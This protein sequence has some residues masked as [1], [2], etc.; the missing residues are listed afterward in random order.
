[1]PGLEPKALLHAM[2]DQNASDLHIKVGVPPMIRVHGDMAPLPGF[3][4]LSS[5]DTR[6]IALT[7]FHVDPLSK[8]RKMP[9]N[10]V[11]AKITSPRMNIF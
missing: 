4:A 2:L 8:D 11:P 10:F 7:S 5:D 9:P 3:P 6:T 1:M